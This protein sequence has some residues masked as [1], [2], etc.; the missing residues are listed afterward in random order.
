M[1]TLRWIMILE[2]CNRHPL[3][4][5]LIKFVMKGDRLSLGLRDPEGF[6]K[7]L[8]HVEETSKTAHSLNPTYNRYSYGLR[9]FHVIKVL[10]SY[11][12]N[13]TR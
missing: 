7:F 13:I 9:S 10:L 1:E 5:S 4:N 6:K 3:F 8:N 12:G 2:N 11:V